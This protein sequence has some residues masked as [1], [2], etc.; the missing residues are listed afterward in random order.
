MRWQ[1]KDKAPISFKVLF[2]LF[3]VNLIAQ[4]GSAFA[5]PHWAPTKPDAAHSF[6]IHFKGGLVHYV[7]PWLG[8]YFDYG[9]G[10]H[11]VLLA[12]L[13]LIMWLHRDELE[14]IS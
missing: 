3:G 1:F 4:L 8:Q 2:A 5:I 7:Q 10:A 12:L 9:F 11:F 14:R 13:F 6:P